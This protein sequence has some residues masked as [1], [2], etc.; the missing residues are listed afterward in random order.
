M[1]HS[2]LHR[3]LWL[4][5]PLLTTFSVSAW[6]ATI[7]I[8]KT[9]LGATTYDADGSATID[10]VEFSWTD[11]MASG[12]NMQVRASTGELWNSSLV[13]G[14]ITQ[15]AVTSTGTARSSNLYWGTSAK[16][17]TNSQSFSG[18]AT[19][20]S[21][22][23]CFGYVYII[24]SSNV[25]YWTQVVITYTPATITLSK[26]SITGLDYNLGSGPSASQTFTVSGSNIPANL[27][28]TAP[29][30]FE[31]SLDGSSWGSSKTISVT[32]S[33]SS[34]GTLSATTVYVRLASGKSAGN[35]SGNVSIAMAGCNTISGVNPKTVAVSGT[36]SA[37][38]C[39][40]NPTVSAGSLKGSFKWSH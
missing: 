38:S 9:A 4:L 36:V 6:G 5:I 10:N 23:G 13:P 14:K 12:D 16:A 11:I 40:T 37:A 2:F 17:T 28:I 35:Y 27:T 3:V 25:A 22:S 26:S 1:K 7:T 34:G 30:N 29:T 24:R 33:G 39:T 21:P 20:T 18:T 32:L 8:T 31:V 19:K 15:V